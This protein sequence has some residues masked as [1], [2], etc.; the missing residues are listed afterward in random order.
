MKNYDCMVLFKVPGKGTV[1]SPGRTHALKPNGT[2]YCGVYAKQGETLTGTL[3]DVTC[4][5]CL[6]RLRKVWVKNV[7]KTVEK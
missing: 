4:I 3:T 2:F 6:K 5:L 1:T 7:K